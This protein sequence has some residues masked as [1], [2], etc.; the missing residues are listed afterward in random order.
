MSTP[1]P[2]GDGPLDKKI[3][4]LEQ[5]VALLR[6]GLISLLGEDAEGVYRPEFVR[7]L[8]RAA[9]EKATETFRDEETFLADLG[10]A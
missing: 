2:T 5:E 10:T 9:Q 7:D 6:A 8:L 1:T 3:A 4:V